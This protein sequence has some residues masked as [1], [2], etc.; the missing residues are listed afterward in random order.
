MRRVQFWALRKHG[1]SWLSGPVGMGALAA[2]CQAHPLSHLEMDLRSNEIGAEL[3]HDRVEGF[4]ALASK[5]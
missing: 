4:G 3:N 2:A 1:A 5:A